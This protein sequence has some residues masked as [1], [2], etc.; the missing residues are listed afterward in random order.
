MFRPLF[1]TRLAGQHA[2]LPG[3]GLLAPLFAL[4][5][6]ALAIAPGPLG[7]LLALP[8]MQRLGDASYALY[9]LHFPLANLV[10]HSGM[11][12]G[13]R[14]V[15][16]ILYLGAAILLALATNRALTRKRP[17]R[18]DGHTVGTGRERMSIAAVIG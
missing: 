7:A 14:A 3:V 11:P 5:I 8:A 16:F 6:L 12:V 18:H 4:L 1:E 2:L 17:V 15:A 9:L 13:T 10:E